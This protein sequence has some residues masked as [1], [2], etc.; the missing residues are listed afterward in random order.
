VPT[1][2]SPSSGIDRVAVRSTVDVVAARVGR[3]LEDDLRVVAVERASRPPCVRRSFDWP[4]SR[5]T[6]FGS[7]CES[8]RAPPSFGIS[9]SS[10]NP[11]SVECQW[12]FDGICSVPVTSPRNWAM[13]FSGT[14][15]HPPFFDLCFARKNPLVNA[16]GD[17]FSIFFRHFRR[18]FPP[19]MTVYRAISG[20]RAML[21]IGFFP[22][23]TSPPVRIRRWE[24]P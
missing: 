16:C 22:L 13:K 12:N 21:P 2:V 5:L 15:H 8:S 20:L 1:P 23:P 19:G 24:H 3:P 9:R 6:D 17:F 4:A 18:S 7:F 11:V 10:D 14:T